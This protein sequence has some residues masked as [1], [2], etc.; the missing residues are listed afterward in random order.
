M[1]AHEKSVNYVDLYPGA[2]KP[3]LVTTGDDKT[4]KV[5]DYLSKSCVQTMEGSAEAKTEQSKSGIAV[6]TESKIRS[7]TPSSAPGPLLSVKT[8]MRWP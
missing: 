8:P 2:D 1:E 4:V 3:Y 5:W 7:T 6:P